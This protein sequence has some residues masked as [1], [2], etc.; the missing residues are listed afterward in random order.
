M[1]LSTPIRGVDGREVNEILVPKNTNIIISILSANRNP[2]I[3]GP[4]S[5]EWK[6]ERWLSP[7]PDT[8][9]GARIP[10]VYSNL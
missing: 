2:A 5:L 1:P 10:G 9:T 3:W 8:V 6:P 7:L 4:D